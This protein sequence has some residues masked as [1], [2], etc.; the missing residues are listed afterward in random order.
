MPDL[1]SNGFRD[2]Y[3]FEENEEVSERELWDSI[4]SDARK[5]ILNGQEPASEEGDDFN[6]QDSVYQQDQKNGSYE[7][8]NY[9]SLPE[10]VKG[11]V[12]ENMHKM[13]VFKESFGG[14]IYAVEGV[15]YIKC[16]DCNGEAFTTE[17]D[18]RVHREV[19]HDG[20]NNAEEA[21]R[22]WEETMYIDQKLTKENLQKAREILRKISNEV[23]DPEEIPDNRQEFPQNKPSAGPKGDPLLPKGK[24]GYE[25]N[26]NEFFYDNKAF[27]KGTRYGQN[28]EG[29]PATESEG[30]TCSVCGYFDTDVDAVDKHK[31]EH[32]NVTEACK[33]TE[34][35]YEVTV[36]N[37]DSDPGETIELTADSEEDAIAKAQRTYGFTGLFSSQVDSAKKLKE[38]FEHP[39]E[40]VGDDAPQLIKDGKDF[41]EE[42]VADEE[43]DIDEKEDQKADEKRIIN[44]YFGNPKNKAGESLNLNDGLLDGAID[45]PYAVESVDD[46]IYNSKLAGRHEDKIATELW[47]RHGIQYEQAIEQIRAI[48]VKTE[49]KTAITLFGKK[50]S[51]ISEA[52]Q[53]EMKLYDGEARK[54]KRDKQWNK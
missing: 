11:K 44:S 15:D 10:E 6:N 54:P 27:I 3:A 4:D 40:L 41:G 24:V 23:G 45:T 30:N 26:P 29:T 19:Y 13:G 43:Y 35:R 49:D 31:A 9:D 38:S 7:D 53:T 22:A 51:E 46:T 14:T 5:D 1:S 28:Q 20:T 16:K 36:K 33:I 2:A 47:K 52:E 21:T 18:M 37:S 25:P 48:E 42:P 17:E 34:G 12:S 8:T 50:Y 32:F 39:D